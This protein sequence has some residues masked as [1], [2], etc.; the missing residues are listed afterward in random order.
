MTNNKN[1]L[2]LKNN[3]QEIIDLIAL[4]NL[5]KAKLKLSEVDFL[6]E[7]IIDHLDNDSDLIEVS[8]YQILA[9]KLENQMKILN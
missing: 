1:I 9:R 8:K 7:E 5:E 6:I 4:K 2:A 3:L